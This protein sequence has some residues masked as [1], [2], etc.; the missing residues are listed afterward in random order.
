ML[1]N[2]SV[3]KLNLQKY[4]FIMGSMKIFALKIIRYTVTLSSECG[5]M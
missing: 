3:Q 1:A 5:S 4:K 2:E